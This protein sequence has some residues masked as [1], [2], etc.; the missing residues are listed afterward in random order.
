MGR[1]CKEE[2]R[3]EVREGEE[4]ENGGGSMKRKVARPG[5]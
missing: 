3:M 2:G 1:V 5:R 4:S